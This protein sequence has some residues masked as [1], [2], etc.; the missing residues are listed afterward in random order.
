[1]IHASNWFGAGHHPM[2][3]RYL[4]TMYVIVESGSL[5]AGATIIMLGLYVN[6]SPMTLTVL[7][8]A[9]QLAVHRPH[10]PRSFLTLMFTLDPV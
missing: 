6:K 7:D 2:E 8:V 9:S 1:M 4:A 3:N 10:F 5:F